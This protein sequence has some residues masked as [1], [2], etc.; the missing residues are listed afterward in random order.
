MRQVATLDSVPRKQIEVFIGCASFEDR[1]LGATNLLSP[2]C[3]FDHAFL[4]VY[5]DASTARQTNLEAMTR[6]L[7]RHGPV[8]P[9][10][11]SEANPAR[12]IG[13]LVR[14]VSSLTLGSDARVT[15]DISTLT[16]RHLLLLLQAMDDAGL[17]GS[18]RVLYTEPQD[19]VVDMYLPMSVGIKEVAPIPGFTSLQPADKPVLLVIMLGY[20]GDRAMSLF[21]TIEPNETI[22]IVPR[23]AYRT[24]W[25]GRTEQLNGQ[26]I[27]LLGQESVAYADSRDPVEVKKS[28]E[29][30]L[31]GRFSANAWTLVITPLG[32]KP[33]TLGLYLHW[34][35]RPNCS[36]LVYAQP[37]RHNERYYSVGSGPTWE[38]RL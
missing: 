35:E 32:T 15:V 19:Y 17:W 22:L 34:R 16:K 25:E 21:Q 7:K 4:C 6:L 30:V 28:L 24:E 27:A 12:A 9:I 26:L 8:T 10:E 23:P 20:E 13:D 33:Q 36:T 1:C 31:C 38:F 5:D 14:E 3:R 11:T 2:G 29:E 37:L 18:L